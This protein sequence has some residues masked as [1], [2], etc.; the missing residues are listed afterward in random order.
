[1]AESVV[2]V[3]SDPMLGT[4][5]EVLARGRLRVIRVDP[6]HQP[7]AW[8]GRTTSTVVLDLGARDPAAT[9]SWVRQHHSGRLVVL[10][11]PGEHESSLPPDPERLVLRRPLGLS[12]LVEILLD[13][14]ATAGSA[15]RCRPFHRWPGTGGC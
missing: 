3:S 9:S 10:L 8:P 11:R 14:G 6:S 15:G 13:Q 1:M 7:S 5:L 12:D 4:S 2:L